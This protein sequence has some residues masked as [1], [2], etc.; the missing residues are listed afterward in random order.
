MRPDIVAQM[1]RRLLNWVDERLGDRPDPMVEVLELGLPAVDR[2]E[3]VIAEDA[4]EAALREDFDH[5]DG[6]VPGGRLSSTFAGR[7]TE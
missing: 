4:A 5:T 3:Q 2:L 7:R 6:S 1:E